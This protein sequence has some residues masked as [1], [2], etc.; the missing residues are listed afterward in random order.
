M[1]VAARTPR[2]GN[3]KIHIYITIAITVHLL[4]QL[5]SNHQAAYSLNIYQRTKMP[6]NTERSVPESSSVVTTAAPEI[7]KLGPACE[8]LCGKPHY[9]DSTIATISS[10][11]LT[12]QA[13]QREK[14]NQSES[15]RTDDTGSTP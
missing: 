7:C 13:S 9:S 11:V 4:I 6:S 5:P 15:M 10:F 2:K 8:G 1:V 12:Y 3:K 14:A